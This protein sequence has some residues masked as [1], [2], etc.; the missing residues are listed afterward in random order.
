MT[1]M[2]SRG[3]RGVSEWLVLPVRS[4]FQI[5][6]RETALPK[7]WSIEQEMRGEERKSKKDAGQEVAVEGDER[8]ET[9]FK[10]IWE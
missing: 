8:A 9:G 5:D 1:R 6:R 2:K 10:G 3:N 7:S 4:V